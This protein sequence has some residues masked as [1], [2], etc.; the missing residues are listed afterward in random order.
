MIKTLVSVLASALM[1]VSLQASVL[2]Q[3]STNYPYADGN[4]EG[5]GQWYAYATKTGSTNALDAFVTNNVLFLSTAG[6]DSVGTPTNGWVNP[7]TLTFASFTIN[8]SQPPQS[9]GYFCEFRDAAGNS[10]CH[11]YNSTQNT[12]VPGTYRF[13]I[14]NFGTA[15]NDYPLDLSTGITYT[16]VIA[17]DTQIGSLFEGANLMINPSF[18]DYTNLLDQAYVGPGLGE[19]FVFGTDTTTATNLLNIN[20]SR[21]G[22]SPYASAGISNVIAGTDF[23]DVVS[24]NLPVIGIQPASGT[25]YSGN[26]TAFYVVASGVDLTYQWFSSGGPL[27]DDGVNISGATNN[28]LNI[29]SLVSSD[30]YYVV[31]TDA[32]GNQVTSST[33]YE[34]VIT[35]P[36]AP[37]FPTNVVAINST[38]NLFTTG[39]FTNIARGTGP[40]YYQWYF[41]PVNTPDTFAPLPGQTSPALSLFLADYTLA[42]KYYVTVSN[43]VGGGSIATGPTNSLTEIAPVQA[44][45][46]QLH[47]LMISL[48][49]QIKN[50]ST[51]WINTNNVVVSGYVTTYG[52]FGS[53]SY[54]EF[55]IQ[56]TNGYGVEVYLGGN[57]NTNT[58]PVGTYVTVTGPVEVYNTGLE[59]APASIAA[60]QTNPAP[61]FAL[62]PVLCNAIFNDLATNGLGT[63][64]ILLQGSLITFTN[65]NFFGKKIPTNAPPLTFASNG[66]TSSLYFDI[67]GTNVSGNNTIQ[68]FQACYNYGVSGTPSFVANPFDAQPIPTNCYQITGVYLTYNSSPEILP[69]R[70]V[71]YV[72]NPPVVAPTLTRSNNVTSVNLNPQPGSTYSVYTATNV[73]GPWVRRTYGLAYYPANATFVETN[74]AKAGFYRITT[75]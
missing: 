43:A 1:A 23:T 10:V 28:I 36:T 59:I 72:N 61:P 67:G 22:F 9:A 53:S 60:I 65:V 31:A 68:C 24:T 25:N 70:L 62:Q 20:I 45:I 69:S 6:K 46:L 37:F 2:W 64:A 52:G 18:Q 30:S 15:H 14:G 55:F 39:G 16:V 41:A 5:Q 19:G 8:V 66:V 27:A 38:N 32:Y 17:Y 4:L 34:T 71:D 3:D 51:L 48:R 12:T 47:N 56:D 42:G 58:P 49:S 21:I 33:A 13:G 57:G 73:A 40:L 44:T 29:S 11:L 26:P 74:A 75:P 35:D 50:S 7:G 63:N 54:T